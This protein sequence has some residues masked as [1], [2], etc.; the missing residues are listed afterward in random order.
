MLSIPFI[1]WADTAF[2]SPHRGGVENR[3]IYDHE[4]VYVLEG[5]GEIILNGRAYPALPDHLFLV[6]PRVFHSFRADAQSDCLVIGVHFDWNLQ[7]DSLGFS[8]FRPVANPIEPNLFRTPQEIRG[9][10]LAQTPFL[11]LAGRLRVRKLLENVVAEYGRGDEEARLIAGG[12]LTAAMG[13]IAREVRLLKELQTNFA[14][15][16]D[17]VRRVQKAREKLEIVGESLSIDE[18]AK[19]VGWSADHLRRMCKAVLQ[20]SPHQIQTAARIRR[21]KELLRYGNLPIGEIAARC[22][23]EDAGHFARVFRK[24]TGMVPREWLGLTR[25]KS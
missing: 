9:W 10:N 21:A 15:G 11:D 24:E 22:G 2:L 16:A 18:V 13:Q 20:T 17:A 8:E 4:W 23:F 6:Q 12:F 7:A 19:M 25:E 3:Q 5:R 14:I 1:R